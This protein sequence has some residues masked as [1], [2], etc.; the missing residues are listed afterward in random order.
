MKPHA[1]HPEA[2]EEYADAANYYT[3]IY[4]ELGGRFFDEISRTSAANR[5]VSTILTR[6]RNGISPMFS[7][8]R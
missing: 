1:F 4:P 8:M 7:R 6:P 5:S 2:A 3:Q